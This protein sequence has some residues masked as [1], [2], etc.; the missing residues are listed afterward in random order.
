[1]KIIFQC[2][3]E[4]KPYLASDYLSVKVRGFSEIESVKISVP[5]QFSLM[6]HNDFQVDGYT[7]QCVFLDKNSTSK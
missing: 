4:H 1:M 7:P 6:R 5:V 3:V 2:R